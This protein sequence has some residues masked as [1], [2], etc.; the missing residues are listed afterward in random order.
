MA[1]KWK[2]DVS[3]DRKMI[4]AFLLVVFLI[5]SS[6]PTLAEPMYKVNYKDVPAESVVKEGFAHVHVRYLVTEK[7]GAKN[8][9]MRF[10]EFAPGGHTSYHTHPWEHEIFVK[11]GYGI[12]ISEDK[13]HTVKQGDVIF[14]PSGEPHQFINES[15][16]TLEL[17]C[18]IPLS[19]K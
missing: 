17:I 7:Q 4:I 19:G 8:F 11:K 14:I 12:L 13:K 3:M 5:S 6:A 10:F 16:E 9:A 18:L 15:N 2:E 1:R